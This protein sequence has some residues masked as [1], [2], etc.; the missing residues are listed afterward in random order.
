MFKREFEE[1]VSKYLNTAT[2]KQAN[3]AKDE[4]TRLVASTTDAEAGQQIKEVLADVDIVPQ[5]LGIHFT[6]GS[7]YVTDRG[8]VYGW[9]REDQLQAELLPVKISRTYFK[10]HFRKIEV[11]N[12]RNGFE[13]AEPLPFSDSGVV[14]VPEFETI[15]YSRHGWANALP[16]QWYRTADSYTVNYSIL[17]CGFW[18]AWKWWPGAGDYYAK[19]PPSPLVLAFNYC[20]NPVNS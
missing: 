7:L 14:R 19:N 8:L 13:V 16:L 4:I 17:A 1:A 6:R 20:D 12:S 2:P 11:V 5:W 15:K 3:A 18:V 10:G 9:W